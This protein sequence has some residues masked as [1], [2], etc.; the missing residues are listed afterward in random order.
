MMGGSNADNSGFGSGDCPVRI[1]KVGP[2]IA[3]GRIRQ[4]PDRYQTQRTERSPTSPRR[5]RLLEASSDMPA[6]SA[7]SLAIG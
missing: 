6:L 1:F 4:P 2:E 7:F 3:I 5:Q